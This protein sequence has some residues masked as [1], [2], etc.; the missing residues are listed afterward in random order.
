MRET[1]ESDKFAHGEF[2]LHEVGLCQNGQMLGEFTTFPMRNIAAFEF[3]DSGCAGNQ[4]GD[5]AEN[6][7]FARAVRTNE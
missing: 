5:H 3:H 2:H 7:R 4:A 1:P 6:G